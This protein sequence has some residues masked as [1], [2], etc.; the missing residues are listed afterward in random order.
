MSKSQALEIL[1]G[2]GVLA[3]D[4]K[5]SVK[6]AA[7]LAPF[8]ERARAFLADLSAAVLKD[9]EAKGFPDVVTF[10]F[11][12]RRASLEKRKE[13]YA[14]TL[15]DRL[16]R[17]CVFHVAPSN[18]PIN[19]AYSLAAAL[20]AGNQSVVKASSLDFAQ[21]RIVCR[22]ADRLL[23]GAHQALAPYVNVVIYP[24]ERQEITEA[25]SAACDVRV[26]WGGDET[27]RRVREAALPPQSFDVTFADRYSLLCVRA[28]AIHAMEEKQLAQ[29]A[30]GF[31]NDTYLTDQNACSAPRLVYWVGS[32]EKLSSARSRFWEAVRAWAAPRYPVEPIIAVDKLTAACRAAIELPGARVEPM[33][34]NLVVR[35]SVERLTKQVFQHRCA[36]GFFLEYADES[37]KALAP[38]VERRIQT[39]SYLGFDPAELRGFVTANG[40]RGIDRIA[41]VGHTLDFSLTW[42]GYDLIRTLSRRISAF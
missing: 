29:A 42:D 18:V 20:L 5:I 21:T 27:V 3:Q 17:G 31:Y 6:P 19:F 12:C 33:P 25:F 32:G 2:T 16:G 41:P 14:G 11:F 22:S 8:D 30:Q 26:I 23:R 24:R 7:P 40:L 28:E 10:A 35:V 39:L 34:D 36:G 4:G 13:E 9:E 38:I 15:E 1:C 37:L